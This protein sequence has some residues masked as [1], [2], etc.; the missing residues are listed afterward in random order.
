MCFYKTK[1][2]KVLRTKKDIKVYK[3]GTYADK[4]VFKPFFYNVFEYPTNQIVSEIVIFDTIIED[5]LHSYLNC[6]LY[7]LF[8]NAVDL[9]TPRSLQYTIE[10]SYQL[11][12]GEF[13]IPIGATYCL[14]SNGEV[15]SDTLI[16]TG[17]Y[18]KVQP[19]KKYVT[20]EL[21]KEK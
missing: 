18:V 16:Y 7:P 5:G 13:I 12:L 14:N 6:V 4:T 9:Y 8:S 19:G 21:W 20:K 11:F 1:Q 15:V 17:N 3:I 10:L 2:S